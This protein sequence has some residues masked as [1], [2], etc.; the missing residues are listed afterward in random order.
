M[1]EVGHYPS[2]RLFE[3]ASCGTPILTDWWPGLD[4]LFTPGRE[5][6]VART[7]DEAAAALDLSD[8]ELAA[9]A[10]AARERTLTDHTGEARA[11]E[12]VAHCEAA[13]ATDELSPPET[14]P[15]SR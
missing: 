9:I 1:A 12:L 2:A 10:R 4:E 15:P 5:V 3:A 6:L 7:A 11:R 13:R 8:A 14:V